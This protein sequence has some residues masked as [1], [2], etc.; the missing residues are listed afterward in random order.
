MGT[1]RI[2]SIGITIFFITVFT[3]S[4]IFADSKIGKELFE[5]KNSGNCTTCHKI[6]EDKKVGPGLKGIMKRYEANREFLENFLL[7][8]KGMWDSNDPLIEDMKKRMDRVGKPIRM[9]YKGKL[10]KEQVDHIIDYLETLN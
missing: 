10:N 1:K 4:N 2:R 8:P 7:D 9:K 5:N 3:A 6:N